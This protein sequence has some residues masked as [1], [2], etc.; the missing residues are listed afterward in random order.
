VNITAIEPSG[1]LYGS[2]FCLFDIIEGTRQTG[3]DWQVILPPEGGFAK[4]L[5]DHGIPTW[6]ILRSSLHTRSRL[7][8]FFVYHRLR[9]WVLKS[10]PEVVYLNQAGMLRGVNFALRGTGIPLICQVQTLED[11]RLISGFPNE[12]SPVAAFI[13]NSFFVAEAAAVPATKRCVFYQGCTAPFTPLQ[14]V[15]PA[16]G[17]CWKVG[18]L[19]RI[20]VSKGHYVLLESTTL[21]LARGIKNFKVVVIGDGLLPADLERFQEEVRNAGLNA[22]FEFRGYRRNVTE[23]LGNLH[24]LVVP[25]LAEPLGRVLLD[26]CAAGIPALVSESGG[27]GEFS[28]H[29][30]VGWR[31]EAGNPAA[32][33]NAMMETMDSYE[34]RVME[35][36]T[37]AANL[38]QRLDPSSY[39]SSVENVLRNAA[40]G[41]ESSV[42]WL[43]NSA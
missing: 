28:R 8:R 6:K 43:G 34:V 11:A 27:L 1:N 39:F 40:A 9:R 5:E 14:F 10:R 32:L 13:F 16:A 24:F 3:M 20:A 30:A 12:Y 42:N 19:G 33:T 29:F 35:F 23:E 4:L 22:H 17:D 18:I 25:S 7:E 38:L 36:K 37:M 26:A 15:A 41:N 31:F 2:E 21:L